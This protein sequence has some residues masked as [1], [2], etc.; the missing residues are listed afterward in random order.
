MKKTILKYFSF[1][2]IIVIAI[3]IIEIARSL[4]I[5]SKLGVS[6]SADIFLGLISIPDSLIVLVGIDSI[7]GVVNSEFS[8]EYAANQDFKMWVLF[9]KLTN[10]IFW[11]TLFLTILIIFFRSNLIGI[12]LPGFTGIKKELAVS[13][14][15][16]IFPIFFLKSVVGI[17]HAILNSMKKFYFPVI[18]NVIPSILMIISVFTPL[19]DNNLLFNLA[20][21]TLAGNL[22]I[23]LFTYLKIKSLGGYFRFKKDLFDIDTK[24]ILKNCTAIIL[25]LVFEQLFNLSKNIFASYYGDGAISILNYARAFPQTIIGLILATIFSVL[26]TNLSHIFSV[27]IKK[28]AK[29]LFTKV[30]LGLFFIIIPIII[31]SITND[32]EIL[33]ILYLRGNF[34]IEGIN[35]TLFP[36]RWE[37]ISM[38]PNILY[39]IP[40][41]L[42]LAKKEYALLNKIGT[43]VYLIGIPANYLFTKF[44]GFY[45]IP[46]ANFIIYGLYGSVL[47]YH[48]RFFWGRYKNEF[49]ILFR[50]LISGIL[51][52]VSIIIFKYFVFPVKTEIMINNIIIISVSAII[53]LFLFAGFT[54]L[55]KAN[56]M[57][58]LKVLFE[59]G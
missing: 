14:S 19:I 8:S 13:I 45:G 35:N 24:R 20:W 43:S 27:E 39:A 40:I 48:S 5:A 2:F 52:Y 53:V 16:I 47:L 30:M 34:S 1:I 33:S 15:L 23:M 25:L 54:Y 49:S 44:F 46:I 3:K 11:L 21:A 50:L 12:L 59:K 4:I 17:G 36:F 51:T 32:S 31:I 28:K 22:V 41:A 10:I 7:K 56:F 37:I 26:L 9:N 55:F 29:L 18:I 42:F 57:K 58:E 38:F 6:E